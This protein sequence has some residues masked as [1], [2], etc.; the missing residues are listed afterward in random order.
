MESSFPALHDTMEAAGYTAGI[1]AAEA[2]G[3]TAGIT[4]LLRSSH[5]SEFQKQDQIRSI[6]AR[7]LI[8]GG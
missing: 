3:Y 7:V 1:D 5:L 8:V 2:A 4:D 6:Q